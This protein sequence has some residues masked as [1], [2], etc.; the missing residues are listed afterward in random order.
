MT[1]LQL[2]EAV[3]GA[4]EPLSKQ[5]LEAIKQ[6]PPHQA[7]ELARVATAKL[8]AQ[9]DAHCAAM[10]EAQLA[11]DFDSRAQVTALLK[12]LACTK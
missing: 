12:K 6:L 11:D 8:A 3:L 4:R 7:L 1:Y 2:R 5:M 9:A 10:V